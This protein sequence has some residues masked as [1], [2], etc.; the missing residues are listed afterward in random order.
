MKID[1]LSGLLE[2]IKHQEISVE[3]GLKRLRDFPY[4]DL[5]F[6]RVD[7][8]RTLRQGLPEV[9]YGEGKTAHQIS[10]ILKSLI[11]KM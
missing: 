10:R 9:I 4:E 3:E 8:H 5:G 1:Q 2:A 6:A 11:E 7:N